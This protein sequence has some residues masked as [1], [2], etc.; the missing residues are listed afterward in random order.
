MDPRSL[1]ADFSAKFIE[2]L[3]T[4]PSDALATAW[5]TQT[6][7]TKFYQTTA[8]EHVA[9]TLGYK[10]RTELFKV[11]FAMSVVKD[12]RKIPIIFVESENLITTAAH[13]IQKLCCISAPL[14][15]LLSVAEWDETKGVWQS[16]GH[17][18]TYL[19]EWQAIIRAHN[20]VWSRTG[21]IGIVV[22]EW[23]PTDVLRFYFTAIDAEG[24]LV[25]ADEV[26]ER[27]LPMPAWRHS[28][29]ASSQTPLASGPPV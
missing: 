11:D 28:R 7:R 15:I 29:A 26:F 21:L 19:S 25:G 4:A 13:E 3:Q 1:W 17:R 12:D 8:L 2:Y 20:S 10:F 24:A 22:G 14:R 18:T 27:K 5:S 23:R 16:G 9:S 6:E